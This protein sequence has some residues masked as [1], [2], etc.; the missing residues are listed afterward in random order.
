[1]GFTFRLGQV[2][3]Q[4]KRLN[5]GRSLLLERATFFLSRL[6]IGR[7]LFIFS[8]EIDAL[9]SIFVELK[10]LIFEPN[11]RR[12]V[13]IFDAEI[14]HIFSFKEKVNSRYCIS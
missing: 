1:M 11:L 6:N 8:V 7:I 5:E 3:L 10:R 4:V 13:Q 14:Q 9:W 12:T 2:S